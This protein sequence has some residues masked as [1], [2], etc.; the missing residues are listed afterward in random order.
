VAREPEWEREFNQFVA[1]G[2]LPGLEIVYFPNDHN[3]GTYPGTATPQ[4]YMADNDLAL[5]RMVDVVSHS[6]YWASTA[7]VVLEDDAQDGPDH[8]DAHRSIALVISPHTQT[9][10]LDSTRYDTAGALAT[11]EELLGLPPMSIFDARANRMWPSFARTPNMR[12]Y[13]AIQPTVVP[14]GDPGAPV[15]SVAAPMA[16]ESS[17]M[18]FSAPDAA[19]EYALNVATWKSVK[20]ASS[21]MPLPRHTLQLTPSA[22]GGA[23]AEAEQEARAGAD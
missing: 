11:V 14:F 2:K 9:G 21:Q 16:F 10:K 23:A 13:D 12:P 22:I 7:I 5:G 18:N 8:V 20:G 15:N 19:P 1:N 3:A 6:P 4:S 17:L